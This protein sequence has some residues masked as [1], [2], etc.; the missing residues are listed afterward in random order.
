VLVVVTVPAC[1]GHWATRIPHTHTLTNMLR[2]PGLVHSPFS[3]PIPQQDP[4]TRAGP[5]DTTDPDESILLENFCPEVYDTS[6][7]A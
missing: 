4:E 7:R 5:A 1:V 3:Q 6:P 2:V